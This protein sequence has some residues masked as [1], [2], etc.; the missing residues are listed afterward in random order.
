MP[1]SIT[2]RLLSVAPRFN[3]G[4]LIVL[5]LAIP[6]RPIGNTAKTHQGTGN[7]N[8]GSYAHDGCGLSNG[9]AALING[10]EI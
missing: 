9:G 2:E 5:L 4:A 6:P 8:C 3:G 1:L 10:K 7:R